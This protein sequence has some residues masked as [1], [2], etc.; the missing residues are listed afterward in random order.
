[1]SSEVYLKSGEAMAMVSRFGYEY[2]LQSL[3][4]Q[5][6]AWRNPKDLHWYFKREELIK[7]L[8]VRTGKATW[9]IIPFPKD[10]NRTRMWRLIALNRLRVTIHQGKDVMHYE[11]FEKFQ[12]LMDGAASDLIIAEGD[13]DEN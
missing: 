10:K 2:S 12:A 4:L 3:R 9:K 8:K 11:D 7:F 6:F 1:M 13:K 5:P